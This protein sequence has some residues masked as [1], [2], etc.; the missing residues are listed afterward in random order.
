MICMVCLM[1]IK[2]I[3]LLIKLFGKTAKEER[4]IDFGH[5]IDV[6]VDQVYNVIE[7]Y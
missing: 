2:L 5:D 6:M 4:W 7:E 3:H 1:Q